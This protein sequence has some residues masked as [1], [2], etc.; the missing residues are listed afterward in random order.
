MSDPKCALV[1]TAIRESLARLK[2]SLR[3]IPSA[4]QLADALTKVCDCDYLRHVLRTGIYQIRSEE[5]AL[6][7]RA[8]AKQLRLERGAA[9]ARDAEARN[10][11]KGDEGSNQAEHGSVSEETSVEDEE[12]QEEEP[13]TPYRNTCVPC[14]KKGHW[15]R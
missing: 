12:E 4:L 10:K 6:A 8:Q 5:R 1:M 13:R 7:D 2:A 3:W 14:A 15:D 11:K 9:R